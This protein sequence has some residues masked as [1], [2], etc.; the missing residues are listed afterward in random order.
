[1]QVDGPA[2][3]VQFWRAVEMLSPPRIPEREQP[4]RTAPDEWVL[5]FDEQD[6]APWSAG[7]PLTARPLPPNRSR[8]YTVYGGLYEIDAVRQALADQF[9]DDAT[10]ADGRPSGPT[11]LFAFTSTRTATWP[12]TPARCPRAPGPSA[13]CATPDRGPP[14]G[15]AA[16]PPR[17]GPSRRPSTGWR[18]RRATRSPRRASPR[19]R[20]RSAGTPRTRRSTPPGLA[21]RRCIQCRTV[22][23]QGADDATGQVLLNSLIA[24]D[25]AGVGRAVARGDVGVG[26][27][28]YLAGGAAAPPS[29]DVRRTP[30]AVVD[31]VEPA[32]LPLGRWPGA[33]TRALV[34][35]QQFAVNQIM[36][37]LGTSAG[38]FAVNGP[39]GTGKTTLLRDVSP[40]PSSSAAPGRWP[41]FEHRLTRSPTTSR[42]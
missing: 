13:A 9:G 6:A 26:L 39:P 16:S 24:D 32:R 18:R 38:V 10:P 21:P 35:S 1:V 40:P 29:V 5:D 41:S 19:R 33:T 42:R 20:E 11:A 28:R 4:R 27:Q 34:L 22:S 30:Q 2:R 37:E 7:Q 3:V 15:S 8:Q 25:L 36:A 14:T 31:R 17:H 12:R 23:A